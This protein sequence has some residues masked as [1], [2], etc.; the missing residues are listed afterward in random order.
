MSC[1]YN[2]PIIDCVS[3]ARKYTGFPVVRNDS[4]VGVGKLTD[5][6]VLFAGAELGKLAFLSE[7]VALQ[8]STEPARAA[9][10]HRLSAPD[11][12]PL[13]SPWT[14]GSLLSQ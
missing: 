2:L 8:S 7:V 5:D 9:E 11:K 1:K 6:A 3:V 10:A 4:I 14:T 12:P 13:T